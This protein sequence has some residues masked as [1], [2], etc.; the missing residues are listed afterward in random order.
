M[1]LVGLGW[2]GWLAVLLAWPVASGATKPEGLSPQTITLPNGPTSLKGMGESFSASIATGTASYSIPIEVPPGALAP[3]VSLEYSSGRGKG[4]LGIGWSLPRFSI[5]RTTAKGL[6]D[7]D[8]SDQFAVEG[9]TFTDE[10]VR[11]RVL[12]VRILAIYGVPLG[13]LASG[14]LIEKFG[15]GQFMASYIIT[16]IILTI[17]IGI[18]WRHSIWYS[19]RK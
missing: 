5:Y 4:E 12:G 13:L 18:K 11:G 17:I 9:P 19:Q 8:E 2:L 7:Y 15:Y 6:P 16:G 10:L 14:F 3:S 1:S